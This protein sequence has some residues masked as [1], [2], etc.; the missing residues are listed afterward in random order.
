MEQC[1]KVWVYRVIDRW[2][3]GQTDGQVEGQ[4]GGQVDGHTQTHFEINPEPFYFSDSLR[5]S[6]ER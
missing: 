2:V 1:L 3:D 4:T 6:G 5:S